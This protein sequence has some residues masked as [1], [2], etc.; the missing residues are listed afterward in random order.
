MA[1]NSQGDLKPNLKNVQ[2]LGGQVTNPAN[3]MNPMH[4][5]IVSNSSGYLG[6]K[7]RQLA[8]AS[9]STIQGTSPFGRGGGKPAPAF[10]HS[11]ASDDQSFTTPGRGPFLNSSSHAH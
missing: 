7:E 1:A 5:V 8:H 4:H 9:D 6:G 11:V 10:L 3:A 2:S